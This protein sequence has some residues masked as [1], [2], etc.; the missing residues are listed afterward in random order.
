MSSPKDPIVQTRYEFFTAPSGPSSINNDED[1]LASAHQCIHALVPQYVNAFDSFLVACFSHHPLVSLLREAT[2]NEKPVLGIF[3]ASVTTALQLLSPKTELREQFGIVSTGQVWEKLL[4]S[5][6]NELLGTSSGGSD[7]FAGVETTGLD[8]T[9]LHDAPQEEVKA[10]MKE[11]TRRLV[12]KGNVKVVILGCAGMA[13]MDEW[14]REEVGK[15]VKIV[16]GVKAGIGAL[17]C[18]LNAKF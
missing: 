16:D 2:N 3:E 18:L 17:Q 13:G 12:G 8:A 7:R 4:T 14:V 1:A 11:A 10:R 15:D 5:A 9:D 6:V